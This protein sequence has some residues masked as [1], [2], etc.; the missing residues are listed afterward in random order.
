MGWFKGRESVD[1]R[2]HTKAG[3]LVALAGVNTERKRQSSFP[4]PEELKLYFEGLQ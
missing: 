3:N 4:S 1:V 2:I